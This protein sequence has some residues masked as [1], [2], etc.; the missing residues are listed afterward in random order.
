MTAQLG[1]KTII[2][3]VVN[4]YDLRQPYHTEVFGVN[5]SWGDFWH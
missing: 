5:H 1:D 2:P 3:L 4:G